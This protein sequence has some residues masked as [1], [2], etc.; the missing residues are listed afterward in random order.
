MH[1]RAEFRR[2]IKATAKEN[3]KKQWGLS[4]MLPLLAVLIAFV[5]FAIGFAF[6]FSAWV[7]TLIIIWGVT[8]FVLLPLSIGLSQ[9][10]I[11]IYKQEK[12]EVSEL[13]SG[14]KGNYKRKLGG[15][16][17]MLLWID[18]WAIAGFFT[19]GIL[20]IIKG[21]S[22]AMTPYI[23][24]NCPNVKAK[25]ALKLSMRMTQGYKMD[26]FVAEL[27]F[28]GWLMLSALTLGILPIIFTGPYMSTTFAGYYV[29]LKDKAI[30]SGTISKE[31][32]YPE[33]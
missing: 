19:L 8:V 18:I 15:M 32:F 24:A 4:I 9:C 29:K 3:F 12:T 22:Y 21:I 16:A 26:L 33:D 2:E 5:G 30:E 13:F 17:W 23:L 14:F 10:F 28:I 1:N 6:I 27:S 11:K 7:L 20:A 25:D 31:E